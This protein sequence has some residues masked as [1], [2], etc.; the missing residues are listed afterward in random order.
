MSGQFMMFLMLFLLG[1]DVQGL[2]DAF[3]SIVGQLTG[4]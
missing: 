2:L 4:A 1:F 3:Q